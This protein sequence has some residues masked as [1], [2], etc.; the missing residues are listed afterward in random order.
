MV[1]VQVPDSFDRNRPCIVLGPSSGSR[2][3]YGAIGTAGE[4]GLKKGCAVALTDA[5]KGVGLH[6]LSDDTVNKLDGTR[7]T[8][9]DAGSLS[10]FAARLTD[11]ARAAYNA[12]FPN[13]I[14][15][16]H[17]HSQQNPE[18]DWATTR[19][20]RPAMRCSASNGGAAVL[21]AAE[22]DADGLI[23]GVVASNP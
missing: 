4:W 22:L 15:I 17:A 18:K 11:G 16:K 23:D 5:G 13:R 1:A 10:F 2:G 6:N 14:A 3:V 7:A 21:R 20:P 12:A 19:W 9:T 8:R